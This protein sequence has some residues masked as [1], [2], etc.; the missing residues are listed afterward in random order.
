MLDQVNEIFRYVVLK[1]RQVEFEVAMKQFFSCKRH[2]R[3]REANLRTCY[4]R[5]AVG[6]DRAAGYFFEEFDA[7]GAKRTQTNDVG[8]I[9]RVSNTFLQLLEKDDSRGLIIAATNHPELLDR[10]VS[11]LR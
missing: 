5:N 1:P 11:P 2:N 4:A 3:R 10:A 9:R 6:F 8:G 7:L